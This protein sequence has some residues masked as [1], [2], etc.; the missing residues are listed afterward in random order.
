MCHM[1]ISKN[2]QQRKELKKEFLRYLETRIPEY[3][4]PATKFFSS[5]NTSLKN[6]AKKNGYAIKSIL[7]ID[8]VQL[9][10]AWQGDIGRNDN[11]VYNNRHRET[12]AQEGLRYYI[13]FLEQLPNI[14]ISSTISQVN[15]D[16]VSDYGN[17]ADDELERYEGRIKEAKVIRH[18]R[19]RAARQKCLEDSGYTC[20][21]CGFNFE[22]AYGEIGKNFLEVH[23]KKPLA[24]YDDEHLIP[25]NELVALCSNCHSMVHRKREV[26]DVE[27]LK[28]C[29]KKT[30]GND[31]AYPGA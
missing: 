25:Q 27:D 6:F 19:N 17:D 16:R 24:T 1:E 21:V 15:N 13:D 29:L 23:H 18:Q 10:I 28:R 2:E 20:Y 3:R 12:K 5:F 26:L 14:S 9:L 7:D 4:M 8:D 30:K 22:K 31:I 11:L